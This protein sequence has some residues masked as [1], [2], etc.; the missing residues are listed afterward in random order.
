MPNGVSGNSLYSLVIIVAAYCRS[1][2]AP[3]C[4]AVVCTLASLV[5]SVVAPGGFGA[6]WEVLDRL[7]TIAA[8]WMVALVVY[9]LRQARELADQERRRAV[10]ALEAKGR[11]LSS[12]S[13]D[14]R[15][16]LQSLVLFAGVLRQNLQGHGAQR[17]ADTMA[18]AIEALRRLLDNVLDVSK[19]DAGAVQVRLEAFDLGELLRR[20]GDEYAPRAE[21][22]GQSLR[23]LP[24]RFWVHSDAALLE[25]VLRN[26]IEN[27]LTHAAANKLLLGCRHRGDL[28]RIDVIDA[29]RGIAAEELNRIFEEFYQADNAQRSRELGHGLGLAIVQRIAGLLGHRLEV[30]SNPGRGTRFSIWLPVAPR[31]APAETEVMPAPA[32]PTREMRVLVVEDDP[33]VL[34]AVKLALESLGCKVAVAHSG[35][36]AVDVA[37]NHPPA[38]VISDFR[39]PGP[40]GIQTISAIRSALGSDVPASLLTG[41]FSPVIEAQSRRLGM[42]LLRKPIRQEDLASLVMTVRNAPPA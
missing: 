9:R 19:L 37:R 29:G 11:F 21:A 30:H 20:L 14:L 32:I 13:H 10:E 34:P 8:M 39:L 40:N 35:A 22:Q 12:A 24:G 18:A 25:R 27:A 36:D 7:L 28:V 1:P 3:F 31:G 2:L 41:D 5:G 16:P 15:Q 26:L 38:L 17:I 23:V 4:W 33:L 6:E 42:G